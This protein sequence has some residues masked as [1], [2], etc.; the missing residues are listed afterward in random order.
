MVAKGANM[1]HVKRQNRASI[2]RLIYSAGGLSRKDIARRLRLTPAAITVITNEM[3]NEGLLEEAGEEHNPGR[4]GRREI[5]VDICYSK[6]HAVGININ[7]DYTVATCL[8]LRGRT[9]FED[10]FRTDNSSAPEQFIKRVWEVVEDNLRE[11]KKDKI[12]GLG[13][14]IRGIVDNQRGVSLE[15][16]G[17]WGET[18]NV[19]EIFADVARLPVGVDNNVRNIARGQLF[20]SKDRPRSFLLVKYG[21]GIGGALVV[22]DGLFTGHNYRAIELGHVVVDERGIPCRC[23]RRGCLETVSSYYAIKTAVQEAY[24]AERTPILYERTAGKIANIDL[25]TIMQAYSGGDEPV[26]DIVSNSMR[27]FALVLKNVVT[28]LDPEKVILYG[29]AFE[30]DDFLNLVYGFMNEVSQVPDLKKIVVRS[31]FNGQLSSRGPASLAIQN[32]FDNGGVVAY[33]I[34]VELGD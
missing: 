27:L 4:A 21:P 11:V 5:I 28:L 25:D 13:V 1:T 30:N 23:N 9:L 7:I 33:P 31:E 34:P 15:S 32:F 10:R 22:E 20:F 19:Q 2:L 8:D 18:V 14:G 6:F 26:I 24:S 3:I 16:Y 12:V 17:L 29:L